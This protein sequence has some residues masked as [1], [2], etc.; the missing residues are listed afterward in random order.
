MTRSRSKFGLGFSFF[1]SFSSSSLASV[2][3]LL[4]QPVADERTPS[5]RKPRSIPASVPILA[6][7][8]VSTLMQTA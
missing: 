5:A 7:A 4:L 3:V 8:F 6:M 1:L 2:A